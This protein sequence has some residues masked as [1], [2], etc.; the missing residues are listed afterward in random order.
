MGSP[1]DR[2]YRGGSI[3]MNDYRIIVNMHVTAEALWG[4]QLCTWAGCSLIR[5]PPQDAC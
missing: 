2:V 1:Q 4:K 5:F 3:V